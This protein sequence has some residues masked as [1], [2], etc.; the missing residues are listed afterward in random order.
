MVDIKV[1]NIGTKIDI[2]MLFMLECTSFFNIIITLH[3]LR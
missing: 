3:H 2:E 1:V